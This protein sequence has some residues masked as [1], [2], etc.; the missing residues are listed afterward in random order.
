VKAVWTSLPI[1]F[2]E[3]Q[4]TQN[5]DQITETVAHKTVN[6]SLK[7]G[8]VSLELEFAYRPGE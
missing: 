7:D 8:Q 6:F 1:Y 5:S 3:L 2:A 4:W